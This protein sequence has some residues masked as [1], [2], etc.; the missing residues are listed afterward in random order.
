MEEQ[1]TQFLINLA[2]A[3]TAVATIIGATIAIIKSLKQTSSEIRA[4]ADI[5]ALVKENQELRKNN[6]A[7]LQAMREQTREM[8]KTRQEIQ[9]QRR[10][11][12]R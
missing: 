7:I 8:N 4:D 12:R 10:N 11:Y 2:P 9:M 1:I 6:Q 5:K 3:I